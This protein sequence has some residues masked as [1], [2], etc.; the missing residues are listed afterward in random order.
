MEW[1]DR[2]K[3]ISVN[4]LKFQTLVASRNGQDKKRTDPDQ[5]ASEQQTY[6]GFSVCYPDKYFGSSSP[7]NQHVI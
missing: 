7:E 2:F 1:E 4:V 5:T 6:Q 3:N